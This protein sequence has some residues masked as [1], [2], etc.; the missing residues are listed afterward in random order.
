MKKNIRIN[1]IP[2]DNV[3]VSEEGKNIIYAKSCK[4]EFFGVYN[5]KVG[6]KGILCESNTP[7][8]IYCEIILDGKVYNN[9]PF[10]KSFGTIITERIIDV[11]ILGTIIFSGIL[12]NNSGA[13]GTTSFRTS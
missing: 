2:F 6:D 7:D 9:I 3:I 4:E 8:R 11:L 10:E 12:I 5:I 1:N 13:I